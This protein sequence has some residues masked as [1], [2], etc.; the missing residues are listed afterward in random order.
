MDAWR[1]DRILANVEA[2]RSKESAT[3]GVEFDSCDG[4]GSKKMGEAF[5]ERKAGWEGG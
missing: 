1:S 3:D 2:F 4:P 5:L